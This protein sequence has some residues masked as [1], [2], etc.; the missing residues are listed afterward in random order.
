MDDLS[1]SMWTNMVGSAEA[2]MT[3]RGAVGGQIG[4]IRGTGLVC[5]FSG[6]YTF[7]GRAPCGE[8]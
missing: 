7:H 6:E 8:R 1:R 3:G 5:P 2:A 4:T